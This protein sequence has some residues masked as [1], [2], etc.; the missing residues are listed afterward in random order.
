MSVDS[1]VQVGKDI[2]YIPVRDTAPINSMES[3][4]R[5]TSTEGMPVT[6]NRDRGNIVV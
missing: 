1:S 3:V 5:M 6:T 2:T 4:G